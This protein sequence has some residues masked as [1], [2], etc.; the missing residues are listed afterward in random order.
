LR[1]AGRFFLATSSANTCLEYSG[2]WESYVYPL[3]AVWLPGWRRTKFLWP[4]S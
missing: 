4:F 3:L 1:C 2:S